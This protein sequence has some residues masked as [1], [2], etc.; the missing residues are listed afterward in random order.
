MYVKYLSNYENSNVFKLK[1]IT[2]L[3]NI[4]YIKVNFLI[5]LVIQYIFYFR[6]TTDITKKSII[7]I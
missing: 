3:I 6:Y 4:H 7:I 5:W 2:P 1:S